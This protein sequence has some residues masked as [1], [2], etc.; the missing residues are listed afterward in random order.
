[1]HG[2]A[3]L[4]LEGRMRSVLALPPDAREATVRRILER[5]FFQSSP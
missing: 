5:S 4:L 1:V 3:V 2:L